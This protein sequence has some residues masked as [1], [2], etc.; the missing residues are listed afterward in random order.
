MSS[1]NSAKWIP[2]PGAFGSNLQL[3]SNEIEA[4]WR[5]VTLIH[6][7]V[8]DPAVQR[9]LLHLRRI[10]EIS[11][12]QSARRTKG[13]RTLG[14]LLLN[15]SRTGARVYHDQIRLTA[16]NSRSC[17]VYVDLVVT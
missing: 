1:L 5:P 8:A 2:G 10:D 14:R 12:A 11:C 7:S 4:E 17:I 15:P 16:N 13:P 3:P 9:V 6:R